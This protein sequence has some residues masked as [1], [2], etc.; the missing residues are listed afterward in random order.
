[1]YIDTFWLYNAD[2]SEMRI[3]IHPDTA[4]KYAEYSKLVWYCGLS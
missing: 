4:L 3:H 2:G 1:L